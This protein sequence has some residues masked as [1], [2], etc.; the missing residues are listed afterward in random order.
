MSYSQGRQWRH[1]KALPVSQFYHVSYDM[2]RPYNVYGGLQDN[3][4]WIG[5][6][7]GLG[8]TIQ[9]RDW[10]NIGG[11]DGFWAFVDPKD[12]DLVYVEYQGGEISRRRIS[13]GE[14]KEIKPLPGAGEPELR[15]NWNTPI[16]L[17]PNE[18]G[19]IYL[20]GQFLFR[21]RDRGDSWE[22][23]SPDLTTND[24]KKQQQQEVG[25][26]VGR[27]LDRREP[28][29]DLSPSASRRRTAR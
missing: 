22:R 25:R 6:S 19:T 28:H 7:A 21:S 4:T 2:A 23:I 13:T 27:Q 14:E 8:G 29:H 11:G 10:W 1:L 3:G 17:S 26:P 15:F 18:P 20:G 12:P 9:N 24:P 16:H 5:P